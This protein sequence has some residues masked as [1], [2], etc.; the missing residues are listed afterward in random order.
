MM[1]M[2]LITLIDKMMKNEKYDN[3]EGETQIDIP[4]RYSRKKKR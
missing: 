1:M 3:D 4:S 2:K